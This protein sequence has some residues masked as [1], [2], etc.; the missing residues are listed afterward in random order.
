MYSLF[1]SPSALFFTKRYR[2]AQSTQLIQI[3]EKVLLE[4]CY[5]IIQKPQCVMN[6]RKEH[7]DAKMRL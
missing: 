3:Q 2:V 7:I 6:Q 4:K 1:S 5:F